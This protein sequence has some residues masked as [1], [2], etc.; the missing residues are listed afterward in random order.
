MASLEIAAI[1][2]RL[3]KLSTISLVIWLAGFFA[4]FQSALNALAEVMRFGD[5]QFYTE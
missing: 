5:R 3:M 1:L 2:E 4:I